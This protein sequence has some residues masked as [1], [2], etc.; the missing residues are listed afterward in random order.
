[1]STLSEANFRVFF[2]PT[3]VASRLTCSLGDGL[4]IAPLRN[5][6]Q[7]G[8]DGQEHAEHLCPRPSLDIFQ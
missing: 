8:R 3:A 5:P 4:E 6:P 7:L 1:M 2:H